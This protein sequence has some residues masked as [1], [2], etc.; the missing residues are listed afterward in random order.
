VTAR[1]WQRI[2]AASGSAQ[3][4]LTWRRSRYSRVK[5]REPPGRGASQFLPA[6]LLHRSLN[7]LCCAHCVNHHYLIT[8]NCIMQ[9]PARRIGFSIR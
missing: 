8:C 7:W 2:D 6:D 9:Q 4:S 5:C 1:A 3:L